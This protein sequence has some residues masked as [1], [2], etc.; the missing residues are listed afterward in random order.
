MALIKV[1]Y[2]ICI[3]AFVLYC[4]RKLLATFHKQILERGQLIIMCVFVGG[5]WYQLI[6]PGGA[7][8]SGLGCVLATN[9]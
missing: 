9:G 8:V 5:R 2:Q 1:R 4:K 7:G 6:T 3:S